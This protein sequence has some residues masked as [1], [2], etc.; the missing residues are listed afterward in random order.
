MP[1][2]SAILTRLRALWIALEFDEERC[3]HCLDPV[4]TWLDDAPTLG[5]G[6]ARAP[7]CA[8]CLTHFAPYAGPRCPA[9]GEPGPYDKP[10]GCPQCRGRELAWDAVGYFG[11]YE[12][13][14]RDALLRF[15]F[16]GELA[17]GPFL[18]ACLLQASQCLPRPN[19]LVAIPQHRSRLRKRGFNQAHELAKDLACRMGVPL[20]ASLLTR[21]GQGPLQ[22]TLSGEARRRNLQNLAQAFVASPSARGRSIWLVDDTM[23]TGPTLAAAAQA[24]K[25]KG[26]ARVCC[27]VVA[28]TARENADI[29]DV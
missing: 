21:V 3:V 17:Q 14:L 19:V 25:D 15:K 8:D 29:P 10:A 27:L 20:E 28:R 24:L 7:L 5:P 26:A 12:D 1:L 4:R 23:T 13:W 9:C 22:H 18:A 6:G 16:D 11:L 2:L